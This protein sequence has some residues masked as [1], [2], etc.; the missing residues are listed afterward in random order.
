M[1]Q[2]LIFFVMIVFASSFTAPTKTAGGEPR[3]TTIGYGFMTDGN[4][5]SDGR[6]DLEKLT[7]IY[8]SAKGKST[9]PV[10]S[11]SGLHSTLRLRMLTGFIIKFLTHYD[12]G[13]MPPDGLVLHP[14]NDIM[15][16]KFNVDRKNR[17]SASPIQILF[18]PVDNTTFKIE[19]AGGIVLTTGE[20]A[21][22]DKTTLTSA[23]NITVWTFG[24]D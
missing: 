23:G 3:Y 11:I 20:Y 21:F 2:T 8:Q 7:A 1:K 19:I 12:S 24:V 5:S 4:L 9:T 14:N 13:P 18:T 22:V 6:T 10:I 17:T 15:L 16:Y